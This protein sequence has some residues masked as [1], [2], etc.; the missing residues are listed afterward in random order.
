MVEAATQKNLADLTARA[1][2]VQRGLEVK[3]Q[4][5]A[6]AEIKSSPLYKDPILI[7]LLN[8]P[9]EAKIVQESQHAPRIDH[10]NLEER[11]HMAQCD[12]R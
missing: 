9:S 5:E 7:I 8:K 6:E 4:E 11:N 10:Q 12:H 3:V 2:R 1:E